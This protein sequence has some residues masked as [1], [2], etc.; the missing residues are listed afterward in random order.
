MNTLEILGF[1]GAVIVAIAYL[2]QITHLIRLHC[3]F[4]IDPKAWLLW[5]IAALLILP[6]AF[7][8]GDVIFIILQLINIIAIAFVI[9]FSYFHQDRV[10]QKHKIL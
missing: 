2:P 3:A 5:L 10:C 6:H 8:T 7:T 4:G 1:T 9:I